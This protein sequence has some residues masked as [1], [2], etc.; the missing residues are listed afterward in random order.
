M[1]QN[2]LSRWQEVRSDELYLGGRWRVAGVQRRPHK[3]R[4]ASGESQKFGKNL[5]DHHPGPSPLDS[6]S[7]LLPCPCPQIY[8]VSRLESLLPSRPADAQ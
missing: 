7:C 1:S 5:P 4:E 8:A 6:P 3:G 2:T